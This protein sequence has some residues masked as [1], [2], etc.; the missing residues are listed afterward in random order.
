[1]EI[2]PKGA[3]RIE[4][5]YTPDL[6]QGRD[7]DDPP[8]GAKRGGGI[9]IKPNHK[10]L[11]HKQMGIAAG[12]PIS[13]AALEKEKQGASPAEKKRIVFAENARKWHH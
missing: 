7:R 1:M 9:H 12:K 8:Q 11:L 5:V 2:K 13:T 3:D 6:Y 4:R 10:G